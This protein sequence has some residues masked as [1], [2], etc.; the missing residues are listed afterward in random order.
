[1]NVT[2]QQS[3]VSFTV[4]DSDTIIELLL[5]DEVLCSLHSLF[6]HC[7]LYQIDYG[8]ITP[9]IAK[10]HL[11]AEAQSV[12][13]SVPFYAD[14]IVPVHSLPLLAGDPPLVLDTATLGQFFLL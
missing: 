7:L 4:N 8:V 1:M 13:T 2:Q 6:T 10:Q 3:Q 11:L 14:A 9:T 12:L 5:F